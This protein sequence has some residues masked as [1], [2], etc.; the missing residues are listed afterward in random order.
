MSCPNCKSVELKETESQFG[1]KTYSC[2]QCTGNWVRYDDYTKWK[3][4]D[5][6]SVAIN[7]DINYSPEYDTKKASLCPDCGRILIKYKVSNELPF[8]VDHCGTCN[9]I[10]L[11]KNEWEM[12]VKNDLHDKVN[13]FFTS[14]WQKKLR[15]E[16]T[17][18]NLQEHYLKKF[19]E[20]NYTKLKEVKKWLFN[21]DLK[22]DMIAYIINDDPYKI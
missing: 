14:P 1:L 15:E 9:G 22:E 10:W 17:Q 5:K 6:R 7:E 11:D 12:L 13:H 20:E 18:K 16:L 3:N 2:E 4:S 21:S 19:G 8:Y